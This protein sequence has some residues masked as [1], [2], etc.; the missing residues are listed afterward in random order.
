[1]YTT[2]VSIDAIYRSLLLSAHAKY[3]DT[4][5]CP[6]FLAPPMIMT[7]LTVNALQ[8]IVDCQYQSKIEFLSINVSQGIVYTNTNVNLNL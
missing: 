2:A 6:T 5:T 4:F 1:M 8:L 3:F 7:L